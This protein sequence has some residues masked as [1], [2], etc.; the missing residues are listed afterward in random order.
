MYARIWMYTRKPIT[1]SP[2]RR[3]RQAPDSTTPR[4][5]QQLRPRQSALVVT[6]CVV[7]ESDLKIKNEKMKK[8]PKLRTITYLRQVVQLS[9]LERRAAICSA[10]R[11]AH[12]NHV[13]DGYAITNCCG[14]S[15]R[16][17][18]LNDAPQCLSRVSSAMGYFRKPEQR[19]AQ[20]KQ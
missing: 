11:V 10:S 8:R 13:T 2:G 15:F 20:D 1:T 16:K 17:S 19:H 9:H 3:V 6:T 14:S 12:D 4:H 18:N 5:V 7:I